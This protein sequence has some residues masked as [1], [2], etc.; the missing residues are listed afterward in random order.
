M[1]KKEIRHF[2]FVTRIVLLI[3]IIFICIYSY[4]S[5]KKLEKNNNL[6]I[7]S[8]LYNVKQQY[9]D[10]NDE[11]IVHILN[12]D[13]LNEYPELKKY[14]IKIEESNISLSNKKLM[15]K[16]IE[17]SMLVLFISLIITSFVFNYYF[18]K[19]EKN[20]KEITNYLK[21]I[22]N[23][24]YKLKLEDNEEGELSILKNELYKTSIMLNEQA[25]LNKKEKESLKDSLS[26][27]SHQLRTPL[28]SINLMIDNLLEGNLSKE[29]E[30]KQ[31]I[32]INRKIK[33][34]NFLIESLLKLSKF[35]ANTIEF[36]NSNS[37][38]NK[39]VEN[40]ENNLRD[41]LDLNDI[42]INIKG[43][44]KDTLYCDYHWLVEA[45]TN[46][47]KNCIEHSNPGSS[48]DIDYS[49]SELLT[50]IT[51]KD[52]GTGM[53]DKDKNHLFDRFY[54]GEKSN[55]NSI[56]IG[57]SLAK[58]I[59][60]HTGGSISVSSKIGKGTEFTIKFLTKK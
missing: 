54:K 53:N 7:S 20:L 45:L 17:Y 5:Y 30:R 36:N 3:S 56:G 60:E 2:L 31:L 4:T 21:E 8:I 40:V 50:K 15:L 16:Y 13:E 47:V 41:L 33:S 10:L 48:I 12:T 55:P 49:K 25:S 59:I 19:R 37:K 38:I 23:H 22:N 11:E 24:N 57:M 1:N 51:I 39:I 42:T 32:S 43:N 52:H 35:D 34:T 26:D 6:L 29:E 14:G 9:P 18:H 28:T 27:I 44:K 58:T 46:I